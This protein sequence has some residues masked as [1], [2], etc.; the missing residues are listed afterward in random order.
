MKTRRK[1]PPDNCWYCGGGAM[2]KGEG[3]VFACS[4]CGATWN[5]IIEPDEPFPLFEVHRGIQT[6]T[7]Y[8]P[9]KTLVASV[10]RERAVS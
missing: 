6:K 9:S 5:E 1:A 3:G 4:K 2:A 10:K 7:A 8:S